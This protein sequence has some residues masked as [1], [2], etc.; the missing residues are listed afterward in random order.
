LRYLI[1][2]ERVKTGKSLFNT[3]GR[4]GFGLYH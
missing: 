1:Q 2:E 4:Q 3:S